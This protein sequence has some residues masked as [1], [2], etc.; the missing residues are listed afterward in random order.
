MIDLTDFFDTTKENKLYD[1]SFPKKQVENDKIKNEKV[2]KIDYQDKMFT[3]TCSL[4]FT[5]V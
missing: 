5:L 2:K 4:M 1:R 3:H